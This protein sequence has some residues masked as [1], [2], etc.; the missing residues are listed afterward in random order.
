MVIAVNVNSSIPAYK[1]G[2]ENFIHECFTRII[3]KQPQHTFIFFNA[4][5][6]SKEFPDATNVRL[7]MQSIT[8]PKSLISWI[9][10]SRRLQRLLRNYKP[11]IIVSADG[12]CS[13]KSRCRQ[14]I[15]HQ[16]A[17]PEARFKL[18][19]KGQQIIYNF[20]ASRCLKRAKRIGVLS[21]SIKA[22]VVRLHKIAADKIDTLYCGLNECF[23]PATFE[24]KD[25]I[26][27]E[28]ASGSEYFLIVSAIHR[29]KDLVCILKAFSGFKKRQKSSMHLVIINSNAIA[30]NNFTEL[31]QTYKY[32]HEVKLTGTVSELKSVQITAAAYA[33]IHLSQLE[34][35]SMPIIEAMRCQVPVITGNLPDMH[36]LAGDAAMYFIPDDYLDLSQKMQLIFK[37]EQLRQAFINKGKVQSEL[38]SWDKTAGSLWEGLNKSTTF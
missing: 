17:L 9:L 35:Y 8:K 6:F 13:F 33:I 22:N 11:D 16:D 23:I 10:L 15:I 26:K 27:N 34:V 20:F 29:E 5:N 2:Y 3:N 14:Y 28:I 38:Y 25:V 19:K 21:E 1:E 7:I 4:Q 37:D 12:L 18:I 24:E 32:R 30:H 31:L 36:E